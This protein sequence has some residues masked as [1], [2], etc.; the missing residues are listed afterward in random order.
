MG[1]K[2]GKG[3]DYSMITPREDLDESVLTYD[4]IRAFYYVY[5]RLGDGFIESVYSAALERTLT[6]WGFKV[7]REVRIPI[8]FDGEVIAYQR[9]DMLV[10]DRVI[11]ENKAGEAVPPRG[12]KKLTNYLCATTVEVGLLL[13]FGPKPQ[14]IRRSRHNS[15]KSLINPD[16]PAVSA[17][18]SPPVQSS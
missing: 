6:K 15:T 14:V 2:G 10:N 8:H 1:G 3:I 9:L 13:Y 17:V 5:N 11:V 12:P 18:S 7:A 4:I 16:L